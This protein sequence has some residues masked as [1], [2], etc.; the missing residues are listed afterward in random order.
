MNA[1]LSVSTAA[2]PANVVDLRI[3]ATTDL[4]MHI[5]GYDYFGN[6]PNAGFGLARVATAIARERESAANCLLFDNG[7]ALQG[8]PMGDYAAEADPQDLPLHP[9][10]AAMN[11]LGYDAATLGNHDFSYGLPFLHRI[12]AKAD[13]PIVSSNLI[14]RK[15]LNIARH[16]LIARECRDRMGQARML[17]IGVLGFLPP[18]TVTWEPEL[19]GEISIGDIIGTAQEG[20]SEL[21][22]AGADLIVAL[23]HSGLGARLAAPMMENAATALADLPGIDVVIAGH[24]H[25]VFPCDS[26]PSGPGIDPLTGTV[27][28]KPCVMAGFWG[29]HLGVIDLQ[30]LPPCHDREGWRIAASSSRAIA[31]ERIPEDP[32]ISHIAQTAHRGTLRHFKRRVGRTNVPMNSYFTM[33]GQ[34]SGLRLVAMAQRWHMR[35]LL[36]GTRWQGLPILSAAAPF[37]AGGRGGAGHYTDVPSGGLTLRQLAD[38]YLFPN[39]ICALLVSGDDLRCWLER[40]VSIFYRIAPGQQDQPLINPDYPGY[41]FDLI[42]GLRWVLDLAA[43]PRHGPDGQL[44]NPDSRRVHD[45]QYRG[46]PVAS[47]DRF[48]LVTN[49]YRLSNSGVFAE[50]AARCPLILKG[51]TR[52]R[53]ILRRYVTRCRAVH[54]DADLGWQ[55]RPMPGTSVRLGT[56]PAALPHLPRQNYRIEDIGIAADGFLDLRL[57]L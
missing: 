4:H 53:D 34:D 50:I 39:R 43:P 11:A 28:Q 25:R 46:R 30:L 1:P 29:S 40:S 31:V 22:A 24:T 52:T 56:G 9:A 44:L 6:R 33:I 41:N 42:D 18:Q 15:R 55:F 17:R 12:L 47:A 14:S 13:F 35:E 48:V 26:H 5:L 7:D 49:S 57:H 51:K 3:M 23:S 10:I 19:Q 8:S 32:R 20:I 2:N 45:L 38:L 36:T 54:P 37:R 27:A 16:M 21:R